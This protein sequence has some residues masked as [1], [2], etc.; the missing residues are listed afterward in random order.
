MSTFLANKVDQYGHVTTVRDVGLL[1][2]LESIK[3]FSA[4]DS[5]EELTTLS[6]RLYPAGK[7]TR[8]P[9]QPWAHCYALISTI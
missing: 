2:I 7:W 5:L 1:I 4:S 8:S 9:S 3:F 6:D